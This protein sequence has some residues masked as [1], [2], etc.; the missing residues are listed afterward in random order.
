MI[1]KK[2]SLRPTTWKIWWSPCLAVISH[3][4]FG[5]D[6]TT[7]QTPYVLQDWWS[8]SQVFS[9]VLK[10]HLIWWSGL[11]P[12]TMYII[13]KGQK[14][15]ES[16]RVFYQRRTTYTNTTWLHTRHP[17]RVFFL[18]CPD[19]PPLKLVKL[20][21]LPGLAEWERAW[22]GG[23]AGCACEGIIEG[24]SSFVIRLC[25]GMWRAGTPWNALHQN[26]KKVWIVQ[27]DW[28]TYFFVGF[29]SSW[30][31]LWWSASLAVSLLS[32]S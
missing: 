25:G 26:I 16:V 14:E 29:G 20:A 13:Q 2:G 5:G 22:G 10:K 11:F 19:W 18:G 30:N 23:A 7:T 27:I 1:T 3:S 31:H 17:T 9:D 24:A 4:L 32:G 6:R 12:A 21:P 15:L 28:M 8:E